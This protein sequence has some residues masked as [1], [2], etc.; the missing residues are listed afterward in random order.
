MSKGG[1]VREVQ[2]FCP[3][4]SCS[5]PSGGQTLG[6]LD[7][8]TVSPSTSSYIM[9]WGVFAPPT[10]LCSLSPHCSPEIARFRLWVLG[11]GR[12]CWSSPWQMLAVDLPAATGLEWLLTRWCFSPIVLA[13]VYSFLGSLGI[14]VIIGRIWEFLGSRRLARFTNIVV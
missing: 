4:T 2:I 7:G 10:F 5:G 12:S 3:C 13:L 1:K 14:E 9:G 8:W 11:R 6:G